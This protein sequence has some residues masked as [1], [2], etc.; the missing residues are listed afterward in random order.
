MKDMHK[1]QWKSKFIALWGNLQ[2]PT[3][4]LTLCIAILLYLSHHFLVAG[5]AL[6]ISVAAFSTYP[7]DLERGI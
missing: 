2:F 1:T 6:G 3:V 5:I 4:L 7:E